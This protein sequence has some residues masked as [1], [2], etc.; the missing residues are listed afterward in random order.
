M[1]ST[2][3]PTVTDVKQAKKDMVDINTF[4]SSTN[5][6]FIDNTGVERLTLEGLKADVLRRNKGTTAER[7]TIDLETGFIYFDT[8]L[9]K[10]IFRNAANNGWVDAMGTTV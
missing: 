2:V 1:T 10:P 5:E 3:Y 7:P 8:T 9:N 4:V 6:K